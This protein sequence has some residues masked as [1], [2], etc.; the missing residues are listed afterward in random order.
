ML[1][2]TYK[3]VIHLSVDT[4]KKDYDKKM[5][6]LDGRVTAHTCTHSGYRRVLWKSIQHK[7]LAD[8]LLH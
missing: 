6:C 4:T 8:L 1:K 2:T 7:I 3:S 5:S